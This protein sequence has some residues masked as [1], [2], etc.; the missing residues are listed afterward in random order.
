MTSIRDVCDLMADAVTHEEWAIVVMVIVAAVLWIWLP[1]YSLRKALKTARLVMLMRCLP[2]SKARGVFIGQAEMKG[3]AERNPILTSYL[4]ERACA[5]YTYTIEEHWRRVDLETYTDSRGNVRTRTV[6]RTGWT[7]VGQGAS[8]NDFFICDDTGAVRVWPAGAT[9][10]GTRFLHKVCGTENPMYYGKG[11]KDSIPHST[12]KR[13]FTEHGIPLGAQLYIIGTTRERKDGIHPEFAAT[14]GNFPYLISMKDEDSITLR[15]SIYAKLW[16]LLGIIILLAPTFLGTDPFPRMLYNPAYPFGE[17]TIWFHAT[18]LYTAIWLTRTFWQWYGEMVAAR[19]RVS[20][21]IAQVEVQMQRRHDLIR[22]LVDVVEAY[23]RH[24]QGMSERL[25]ELRRR[26]NEGQIRL[27][28]E[29]YPNLKAQNLFGKLQQELSDTEERLALGREYLNT[30]G[31]YYNTRLRV[32]PGGLI[33]KLLRF[34]A[35]RREE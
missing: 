6:V 16:P 5:W 19:N 34:R 35:Y 9:I 25:N 4:T 2:T 27:I 29:A 20:Q 22:S 31:N 12:Y 33:L 23:C 26:V 32:F 18:L 3:K 7:T 1:V 17:Q 14:K 10:E 8:M 11:P 15:N 28:A 21:G 13:R 24:E 30:I